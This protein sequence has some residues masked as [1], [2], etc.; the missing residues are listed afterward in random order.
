V[1]AIVRVRVPKK[2][3]EPNEEGENFDA[4][5]RRSGKSSKSA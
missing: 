3:L 5:S 1:K 2:K 4:T